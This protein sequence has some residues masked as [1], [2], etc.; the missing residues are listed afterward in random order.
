MVWV[1]SEYAE[2]L[3]VV[4]AWVSALVPWSISVALGSIHVGTASGTLIEVRFPFWLIRYLFGVEIAGADQ[5]GILL[6]TPMGAASYY[7]RAPGSLPFDV[8]TVGAGFLALAVLLSVA[9]YVREDRVRRLAVDPVR[10]MG[11]LLL[12]AALA[13]T[14][15][16]W[17][18]QFGTWPVGDSDSFPGLLIP[19]GVVFQYAFA[20][21]LLRV[22][23]VDAPPAGADPA[24]A[25][26]KAP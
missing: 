4:S 17:L 11:W 25:V 6:R 8:W 21:T 15:S 1:N 24:G 9:L 14:F 13:L 7:H 5:S 20:Y 23:R 16:C 18:L 3:A 2:E 12:C 19:V 10:L 26:E 22:E